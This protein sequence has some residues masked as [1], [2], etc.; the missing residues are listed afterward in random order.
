MGAGEQHFV[1][2]ELLR[3]NRCGY[4]MATCPTYRVTRN[5]RSVARGRNEL[6]RTLGDGV[7]VDGD[8]LTPISECLLCGACTQACFG[9]VQTNEIM[10]RARQ[11]LV[12]SKGRPV[13]QKLI[14]DELLGYPRR[15]TALM[16][17][18]S[19]GKRSGLGEIAHRLGLLRWIH[20]A[21]E[22]ANGLVETMP[23]RFL[24]DRLP[25]MGFQRQTDSGIGVWVWPRRTEAPAGAPTVLVFVGCGTNYQLPRQGEAA[26]KLLWQAGCQVVVAPN[27]CCGLPP[28]SYGDLEAARNLARRNLQV[29]GKLSCDL[30]VTEC[31]SCSAFL[32][33]WPLLLEGEECAPEA[34]DFAGRVRDLMELLPELSLPA[35]GKT[36]GTVTY[37]DPCHLGRGQEIR[38]QPRKL[39]R[40]V[41]GLEVCE[42]TEA[43]WCCGGAG[44][45][46]LAHPELSLQ[47]LQRKMGR[48]G[49]TGAERVASACPSCVLQLRYGS[50]KFGPSKPVSHVAELMA[51]GLGIDLEP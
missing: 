17:M 27:V 5:E 31:G 11:A 7:P 10:V 32:K 50:R 49:D 12:E 44:S 14:F 19:L 16:R 4:C 45:Y 3:C 41:A 22:G 21:L 37:H 2:T 48:V 18:L 15:L 34:Q 51:E 38:E 13:A 9:K 46:N 35:A 30:V 6:V 47:I 29:L 8:R 20:A 23:R 24:R 28:Y 33:K 36:H 26:L 42:L 25:G 43:D 1:E 39:L 40:D